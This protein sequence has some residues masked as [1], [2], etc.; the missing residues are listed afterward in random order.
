MRPR[1]RLLLRRTRR[2]VRMRVRTAVERWTTRDD[3]HEAVGDMIRG[4]ICKSW[5]MGWRSGLNLPH[6][7]VFVLTRQVDHLWWRPGERGRHREFPAWAT[8][9]YLSRRRYSKWRVM[10]AAGVLRLTKYSPLS[11]LKGA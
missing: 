10:K 2:C 4:A 9:D 6:G 3:V 11:E 5:R 8:R 1:N 7:V